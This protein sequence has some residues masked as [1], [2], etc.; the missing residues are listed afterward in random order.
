M[1][2]AD[3]LKPE[4]YNRGLEQGVQKGLEQGLERGIAEGAE[5]SKAEI[6]QN[7]LAKGMDIDLIAS[8]TGLSNQEVK[9]IIH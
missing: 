4:I 3:Y 5:K 7:M 1:T 6:A 9:S 8:V 2:L